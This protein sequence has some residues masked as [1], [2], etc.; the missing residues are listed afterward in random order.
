MIPPFPSRFPS[1]QGFHT[2]YEETMNVLIR[3]YLLDP[4]AV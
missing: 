4:R 1:L 2:A 3:A